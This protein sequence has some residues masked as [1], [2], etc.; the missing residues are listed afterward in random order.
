[1]SIQIQQHYNFLSKNAEKKLLEQA[2]VTPHDK[3]STV[4]VLIPTDLH[5]N[6]P[7]IGSASDLLF[8]IQVGC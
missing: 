7:H 2:G 1:M 3:S 8:I 5:E 4:I 6:I